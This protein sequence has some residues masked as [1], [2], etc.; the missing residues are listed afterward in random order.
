MRRRGHG[1]ARAHGRPA[2]SGLERVRSIA[3][4]RRAV[5]ASRH[6]SLQELLFVGFVIVLD[7]GE[8]LVELAHVRAE[9]CRALVFAHVHQPCRHRVRRP[10]LLL[11]LQVD[12][13]QREQLAAL[14]GRGGVHLLQLTAER[15]RR[16]GR[17]LGRVCIQLGFGH[18]VARGA[19]THALELA[20][21]YALE[22]HPRA[23]A[24]G[25]HLLHLEEQADI[26]EVTLFG[27]QAARHETVVLRLCRLHA[28]TQAVFKEPHLSLLAREHDI[29]D[30]EREHADSQPNG[31]IA[32]QD[33][34][35]LAAERAA[36]PRER[37]QAKPSGKTHRREAVSACTLA[38]PTVVSR[39]KAG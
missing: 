13:K 34:N 14:S 35:R 1:N 20:A 9:W 26:D 18:M 6:L 8:L 16:F 31:G 29:L 5:R 36:R 33:A 38:R 10:P 22:L 37:R 32:S 17:I 7:K 19:P 25:A 39:V 15:G 3:K 24:I 30:W 2:D 28:L 21:A 11:R 12:C 27:E 4:G 23:P